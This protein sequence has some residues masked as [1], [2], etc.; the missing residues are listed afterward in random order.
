MCFWKEKIPSSKLKRMVNPSTTPANRSWIPSVQLVSMPNEMLGVRESHLFRQAHTV[1]CSSGRLRAA[2]H[3][4]L[5][6]RLPPSLLPS[7]PLEGWG[8]MKL[9]WSSFTPGHDAL[10][11]TGW[12][13]RWGQPCDWQGLTPPACLPPPTPPLSPPPSS[14]PTPP[15]NLQKGNFPAGNF[16]C[17]NT[18][19]KGEEKRQGGIWTAAP[20][21]NIASPS[22][23][24]WELNPKKKAV[25]NKH[26]DKVWT[27]T[28]SRESSSKLLGR[29][30]WGNNREG[31]GGKTCC[32]F[33]LPAF[34]FCLFKARPV[35]GYCLPLKPGTDQLAFP[36]F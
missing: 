11:G 4:P 34:S 10:F 20:L 21:C 29:K 15:S 27:K 9:L 31:G 16:C 3:W 25:K 5:G 12:V 26:L 1:S 28:L 6:V 33:L 35:A 19:L 7:L 22:I 13:D 23:L 18:Q 24:F 14:P 2:G 17:V 8:K 36:P 30:R 32:V